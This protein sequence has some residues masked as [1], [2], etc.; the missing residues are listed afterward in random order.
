MSLCAIIGIPASVFAGPIIRSGEKISIDSTQTLKGDFYGLAPSVTLSGKAENDAYIGGGN[1]IINAPI[2]G[3]LTILGGVVQVHGE[4]GD[5][6][7]IVGGDVTL[8]KTVKGDVAVVGGSLTILSTATVEGD[9]LFMGGDLVIEGDVT[10]TVHGKSTNARMNAK[11]GG[12]ISYIS[13]NALTLG[14]KADVQGSIVYE[15]ARDIVR[16]QDAHVSGEIHK[17][18][19][20]PVDSRGKIKAYI[21]QA[22]IVLFAA[23]TLLLVFRRKIQSIALDATSQFPLRGLIGLA[24]FLVLPFVSVLLL[25]SVLGSFI[26]IVLFLTYILLLVLALVM[27]SIILG[28]YV[29]STLM[30][31]STVTIGTVVFGVLLMSLLALIP[32]VGGLILF[33]V[34]V[35]TLGSICTALYRASRS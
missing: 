1:V 26:G 24:V 11:I 19:V 32:Y 30:H 29:Q 5:D 25:V 7:R 14:D 12:D 20:V 16:A 22:C 4:I 27:G 15:S 35:A 6:L 28:Y 13:T 23:L 17:T 34:L 18:E 3:D 31:Q 8:G 21:L 33:A 9:V 10:G 2:T